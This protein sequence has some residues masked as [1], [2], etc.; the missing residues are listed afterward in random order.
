MRSSPSQC[1]WRRGAAVQTVPGEVQE[2]EPDA[3]FEW[4]SPDETERRPFSRDRDQVFALARDFD[5]CLGGDTLQHI[6]NINA[7]ALFVPLVQVRA[8]KL[9]PLLIVPPPFKYATSS[10]EQATLHPAASQLRHATS[11]TH[12]GDGTSATLEALFTL[13]AC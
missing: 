13:C 2:Q 11:E 4:L 12:Q 10:E 6:E 3:H 8:S 7:A 1:R 5:L 9:H